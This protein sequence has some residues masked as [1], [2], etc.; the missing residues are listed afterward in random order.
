VKNGDILKKAAAMANHAS[1][2]TVGSVIY[3]RTRSPLDEV[4]QIMF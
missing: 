4:E 3:T 2:R 1:M